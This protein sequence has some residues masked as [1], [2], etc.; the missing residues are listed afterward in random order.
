MTHHFDG[1]KYRN[2][3]L[4]KQF[5]PGLGKMFRMLT[6][7]RKKWPKQ[8]GPFSASPQPIK[9]VVDQL[10]ITFVNHATFLIQ[11]PG[12]NI[13]TDP[14]WSNRV[15]P[16]SWL[17]P[18][19]YREPGIPLEDLPPIDLILLSHNHYD[20]LDVQTLRNLNHKFSPKVLVSMGNKDLIQSLGIVD[21]EEMD[22][23]ED[24]KVNDHIKITFTPA[25]HF[26]ARGLWDRYRT[27]WGSF[28][29][30]HTNQDVYFGADSG[31]ASH[32]KDIRNRLVAPDI[33]ILGI[34]AYDPEWFMSPIHMNPAEAVQAHLDLEARTSIAMHYGTFR[35]AAESYDDPI[36]KLGEAKKRF[37]VAENR[38]ITLK[39][40]FPWS[41]SPF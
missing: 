30:Q 10:T 8:P 20:H 2:P 13:L 31:Y 29:I 26:S 41:P 17:G 7:R 37:G 19:R 28:Y 12:Y 4:N 21:V 35:L 18:K 22:W 11:F 14:V 16:Y 3:T 40:G 34:G 9:N 33:A 24:Q 32:F 38:F 15:S 23:W 25:Q 1:K 5:N 36:I 39:E 6:V 27:L